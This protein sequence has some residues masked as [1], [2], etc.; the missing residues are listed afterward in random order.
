MAVD[1]AGW[2][3]PPPFEEV[4]APA[5]FFFAVGVIEQ[6]FAVAMAVGLEGV[7]VLPV[8]C[9]LACA[10]AVRSGTLMVFP[11]LLDGLL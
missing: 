6:G 10:V 3:L 11:E 7:G 9:A 2:L 1:V 4:V 8:P 5:G